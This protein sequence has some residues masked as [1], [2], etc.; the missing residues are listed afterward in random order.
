MPGERTSLQT[1]MHNLNISQLRVVSVNFLCHLTSV[2]SC[3]LDGRG[4]K[5]SG[6]A[7]P[8]LALMPGWW[9][10][11]RRSLNKEQGVTESKSNHVEAPG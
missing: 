8:L 1:V 3:R 6:P 5:R 7:G 4:S 2:L 11:L 9:Y 10:S